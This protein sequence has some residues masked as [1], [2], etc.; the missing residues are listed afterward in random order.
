MPDRIKYNYKI[1]SVSHSDKSMEVVYEN[2]EYGIMHV[3]V[4][5]PYVGESLEKV[6]EEYA[7]TLLWKE[8]SLERQEVSVGMSGRGETIVY[9]PGEDI[10]ENNISTPLTIEERRE[11]M[12]ISR[13][14]AMAIMY[15][16]GILE[17]V[18]QI[19]ADSDFIVQLAWKEAMEFRR[20]SPLIETLK[21]QIIMKDGL[22]ISEQTLDVMF[23]EAMELQF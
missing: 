11:Y 6:I 18:E 16:Y 17:Q 2:S 4:R 19:V 20:L 22:P 15:Q 3:G 23:S 5:L 13:L 10:S 9:N 21:T 14:Q 12:I 7:P 1:I 8:L